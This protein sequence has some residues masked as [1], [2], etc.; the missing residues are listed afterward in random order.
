VLFA[1]LSYYLCFVD[2]ATCFDFLFHFYCFIVLIDVL[3]YYCCFVVF[4]S[5]VSLSNYF[6]FDITDYR[7]FV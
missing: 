4:Y 7:D 6:S 2:R 5:I 1:V 3:S